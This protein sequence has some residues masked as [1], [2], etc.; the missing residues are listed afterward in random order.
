MNTRAIYPGTFDPI[1]LGH[2]DIITRSTQIFDYIVIAISNSYNKKPLFSLT[3][4]IDLVKQVT[5]HLSNIE[6]IGFKDL[7][8]QVAKEYNTKFIIRG[9]RTIFDFQ[10][11]LQL[12]QMNRHLFPSLE[13][14]FLMPS[15][16]N[17]FISSSLIKE[18]ASVANYAGNIHEFLPEVVHKALLTKLT[19]T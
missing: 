9:L 3:E 10:Y 19:Q 8:V 2:L 4:R 12:L 17:F 16:N 11:E 7:M 18:V 1:T 14:I 13:S 15:E 5:T 6:I